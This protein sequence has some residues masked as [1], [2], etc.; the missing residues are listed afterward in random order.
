MKHKLSAILMAFMLTTP[1]AFAAPE[2]ATGTEAT[3][4][5]TGTTA[6]TTGADLTQQ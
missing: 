5:T 2:A 3:T 4:G 1:A 6:T